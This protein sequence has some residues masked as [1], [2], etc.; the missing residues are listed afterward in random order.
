MNAK[1][2]GIA[3]VATLVLTQ[4][5]C[6]AENPDS[7]SDQGTSPSKSKDGRPKRVR[8]D[9]ATA[10]G[11]YAIAQASG[12]ADNPQSI[13]LVVTAKPSQKVLVIWTMTC[14]QKGGA[15]SSDDQFSRSTP[16][17]VTLKLPAARVTDCS[18][19]ASAQMDQGGKVRVVL[20]SLERP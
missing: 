19:A 6:A 13:R 8:M 15:G 4:A 2:A 11:D 18:V 7:G 20:S 12:S 9:S 3:L 14:A 1:R 10:N 5:G 17:R 16:V